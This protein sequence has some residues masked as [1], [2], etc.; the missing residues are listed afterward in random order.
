[1]DIQLYPTLRVR[2]SLHE[3]YIAASLQTVGGTVDLGARA[4]HQM[5]LELARVRL[6]DRGNGVSAGEEG[7]IHL[8]DLEQRLG[9]DEPHIN[10]WIHRLGLQVKRASVHGLDNLVERRRGL[11]EVRLGTSSVEVGRL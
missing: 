8:R 6:E 11:G 4:H 10:V 3:E 1:M 2:H 5:L 9:K 7:W